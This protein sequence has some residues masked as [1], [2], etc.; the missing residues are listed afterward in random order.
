MNQHPTTKAPL[1]AP[2]VAGEFPHGAGT[3]GSGIMFSR[4]S[5]FVR[6]A[7]IAALLG[8][9]WTSDAF[10]VAFRLPNYMRHLLAE[11]AFAYT[12]VPSF[13]KREQTEEDN[14]FARSIILLL[15]GVF[16]LAALAGILL[17]Q[18]LASLLAPGLAA[19]PE[20]L[21]LATVLLAICLPY[22]PLAAGA[23]A[24]ASL[25]LARKQFTAPA[26]S[27][28][29]FNLAMLAAAVAA[30]VLYGPGATGTP[31]LLAAGVV[32]SG[33]AQWL[34]LSVP[35][36]KAGFFRKK[37]PSP[38]PSARQT[39]METGHEIRTTL[40]AMPA[41]AFAASGGQVMLLAA[42]VIAS[43]TGEGSI[44]ALYFAERLLE[45]P[46]GIISAAMGMSALTTLSDPRLNPAA[47]A[48]GNGAAMFRKE[49]AS[50]LRLTLFFALPAA[51]GAACLAH[52]IIALLYG[53]GAFEA[54]AINTTALALIA[55]APG[56]PALA[57]SRPLLAAL[58][59]LGAARSGVKATGVSLAVTVILGS[60]VAP[61]HAP[62]ALA[63]AV[64][65]AAWAYAA[66]LWRALSA[67]GCIDPV[68]RGWIF[69]SLTACAVM[70]VA[71]L[72][73]QNTVDTPFWRVLV[74]VPCGVG[75][76]L[77]AARL[78]R[79]EEAALCL[80]TLARIA[81]IGR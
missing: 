12:L 63:F 55:Y 56:L 46:L 39:A 74:G 58:S 9:T 62:Y 14:G 64:S 52:P 76:Y 7:A 6:D 19:R 17:R 22:F 51:A 34:Y 30:F 20:I 24:S 42:S 11:G 80:Q 48:C 59:A 73:L 69:R 77:V 35:L 31:Y 49:C 57:L 16:A 70:A 40:R 71:V 50:A 28:L 78:C 10:L 38:T 4:L 1:P 60:A 36:A 26:Y 2:D 15:A 67:K 23:A 41:T 68:S 44:S 21:Q 33:G 53:R 81:R 3:L 32:V 66:V 61:L 29:V 18:P 79:M 54:N 8:G 5:G 27:P 37:T 75:I 43:F 47:G 65:I 45:F 25:L 72:G 13:M